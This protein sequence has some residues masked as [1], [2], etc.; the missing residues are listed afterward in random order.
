MRHSRH[1]AGTFPWTSGAC[2]KVL[3][4][5]FVSLGGLRLAVLYCF[6]G[7]FDIDSGEG[8]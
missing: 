8:L 3:S 5:L 7:V 1:M 2:L 6:I 4:I